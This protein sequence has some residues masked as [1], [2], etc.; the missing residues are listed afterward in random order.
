MP[1]V[2]GIRSTSTMM[3]R[4]VGYF[5]IGCV[6][7]ALAA[8]AWLAPGCRGGEPARDVGDVQRIEIEVA[9]AGYSPAK[10]EAEAGKPLVLAFRRSTEDA[11][12]GTVVIP[13]LGIQRDLPLNQTVEIELPPQQ[14]GII[15]FACAMD[16]MHG[17]VVVR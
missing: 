2:R 17:S 15:E 13:R 3:K 7:V 5:P 16:M 11:C 14:A 12:G 4:V 8:V 9:A 1:E 6:V 10:T